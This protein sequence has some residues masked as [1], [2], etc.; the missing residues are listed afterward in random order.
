MIFAERN[1]LLTMQH[2]YGHS[3]N[4]GNECA[5]HA[6]AL[7]GP[8]ALPQTITLSPVGFII[9]LMHQRV[10]M[11]VITSLRSWNDSTHSNGCCVT[12]PK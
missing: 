8:W 9:I 5:D 12:F 1:L 4:L 6:A 11:A 3:G 2:V 7:G 10:L